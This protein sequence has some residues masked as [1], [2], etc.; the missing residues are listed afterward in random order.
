MKKE[1]T[2][3]AKPANWYQEPCNMFLIAVVLLVS[4]G[5]MLISPLL[6]LLVGE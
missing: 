2:K 3:S 5:Y 6:E 4:C 1:T